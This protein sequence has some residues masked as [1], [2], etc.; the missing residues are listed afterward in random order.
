VVGAA[1]RPS[2]DHPA[3]HIA[4]HTTQCK[5]FWAFRSKGSFKKVHVENLLHNA[6]KVKLLQKS[7]FVFFEDLL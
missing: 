2:S 4:P 5:H 7:N 6:E 3:G 1:P